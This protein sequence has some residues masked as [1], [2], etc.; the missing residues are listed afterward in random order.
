MSNRVTIRRG[1]EEINEAEKRNQRRIA[2]YLR[3]EQIRK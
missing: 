3:D 2:E 1:L